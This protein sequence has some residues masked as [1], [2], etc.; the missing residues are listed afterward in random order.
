[1]RSGFMMMGR[2]VPSG[3]PE[4]VERDLSTMPPGERVIVILVLLVVLVVLIVAGT[5]PR[6]P[7]P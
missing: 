1:M 2:Y 4:V 3:P 5:R 6:S 7:E